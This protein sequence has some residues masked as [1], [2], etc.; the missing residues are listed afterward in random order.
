LRDLAT[1]GPLHALKLGPAGTQE[2]ERATVHRTVGLASRE[3]ALRRGVFAKG[4]LNRGIC[5][6]TATAATA[7]RGNQPGG[8]RRLERA[9]A[10]TFELLLQGDTTGA[11]DERR[12][13]LVDVAR[14]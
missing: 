2:S 3:D 12:V 14:V 13:E 8:R 6:P 10:A 1:I 11:A 4:K 9:L 5:T 7:G